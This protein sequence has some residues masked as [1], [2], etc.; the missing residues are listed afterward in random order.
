PPPVVGVWW[1]WGELA[2]AIRLLLEYTETPYEDKLYSCGEAPNYDKS[3]WINEKEKLGLDFPNVG[4][5]GW[6]GRGW[7]CLAVPVSP[8]PSVPSSCPTSSMATPN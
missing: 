4:V 1:V 8:C 2:H 3:Q 7:G 5:R 6:G